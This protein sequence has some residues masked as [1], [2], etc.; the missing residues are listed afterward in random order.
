MNQILINASDKEEIRVALL[1]DK[2]LVG[3]DIE[4]SLIEKNKGN[5]YK[6]K[7]TRVEQS[8]SAAFVDYGHDKQGFLPFK[9]VQ[10]QYLS[11]N[12]KPSKNTQQA[13]SKDSQNTKSDTNNKDNST[14][15]KGLSVGQEFIVQVDKEERGNKGATLTTFISLAG[16]YSILMPNTPKG[17]AISN[18]IGGSDKR[19]LKEELTK[20]NCPEGIGLIV[21]TSG[22]KK[23][24]EELQWEVDYLLQLWQVIEDLAVKYSAPFLIYKENSL[25]IRTLRD[26]LRADVKSVYVDD[27]EVFEQV[28][29]FVTFVMPQYLDKLELFDDKK[30]SLFEHI[31]VEKQVRSIFNREVT[32]KSGGV[33]VFDGTEALTAID[34]NSAKSN[35]GG[36]IEQTALNTN[37]E[38]AKEIAKQCQLRDL[39][40][41]IVIDFIDMY[42]T[43]HQEQVVNEL[44][45]AVKGDKARIQ[46]GEISKFGLL[47]M[48]RQR[49]KR[50]V[51]ESIKKVCPQCNGSGAISTVPSLSLEILRQIEYTF[52]TGD[53]TQL[54]VQSTI[55]VVT[56][57][58]NEKRQSIMTLEQ[59][60]A[61]K[62]VLLPNPHMSFPDFTITKHKEGKRTSKSY[63]RVDKPQYSLADN[64]LFKESE[65]PMLKAYKPSKQ[66]PKRKT[67]I[68]AKLVRLLKKNKIHHNTQQQQHSNRRRRYHKPKRQSLK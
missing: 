3:L 32:L 64:G 62:V 29:D 5:I 59:R 35:K 11:A 45:K 2:E 49:L 23:N 16:A 28:K 43:E 25:T 63:Q 61:G 4:S 6:G 47:E 14:D 57:L 65:K 42:S 12:S 46:L 58:L 26:H 33:L 15:I 66:I 56:Y 21:R 55:E 67:G 39:G 13:K 50:S 9:E 53:V 10:P 34:I 20:V 38:A 7:I 19:Q 8:L 68:F 24:A 27:E 60:V 54:T 48:S 51:S 17:F 1:Q 31:G 40:G 36:D 22:A 37:L 52:L 18:Q 44:A 30:Q 41:L